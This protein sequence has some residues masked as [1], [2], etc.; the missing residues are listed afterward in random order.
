MLNWSVSLRALVYLRQIARELK[1][2]NDLTA[3]RLSIEHPGVY[4]AMVNPKKGKVRLAEISTPTIEERNKVYW[5]TQ[6]ATAPRPLD[7][8]DNPY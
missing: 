1:R 7:P 4:K 3:T 2:S 5:E 6:A 8:D